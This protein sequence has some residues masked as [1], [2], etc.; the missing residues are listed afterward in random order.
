MSKKKTRA[1]PD[2][3]NHQGLLYPVMLEPE[4]FEKVQQS[5]RNV[6]MSINEFLSSMLIVAIDSPESIKDAAQAIS[7]GFGIKFESTIDD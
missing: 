3:P 4:T 5:A 2:S 7:D 1:Q 6:G